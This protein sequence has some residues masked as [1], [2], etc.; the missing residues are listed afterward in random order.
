[1]HGI[2]QGGGLGQVCREHMEETKGGR[3]SYLSG[4]LSIADRDGDGSG[5]DDIVNVEAVKRISGNG[6]G[7]RDCA[8]SRWKTA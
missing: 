2:L 1:M 5:G 7:G 3:S 6:D 8:R 4:I